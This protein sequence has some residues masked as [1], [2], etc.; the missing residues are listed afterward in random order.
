MTHAFRARR[1]PPYLTERETQIVRLLAEGKTEK[2]VS[3][4]LKIA[5]GT[6]QT[7]LCS[8]RCRTGCHNHAHLVAW[9]FHNGVI[10]PAC[11]SWQFR[12]TESREAEMSGE[13]PMSAVAKS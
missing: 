12:A 10:F 8:A 6:I 5:G 9:A 4:I 1:F 7:L 11:Q 2:E 3:A 13:V